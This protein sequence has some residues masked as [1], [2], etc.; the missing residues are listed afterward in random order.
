VTAAVAVDH[1]VVANHR[2]AVRRD[3]INVLAG[4]RNRH[5]A[6]S[7]VAENRAAGSRVVIAVPAA[8]V[9]TIEIVAVDVA[10]KHVNQSPTV[11]SAKSRPSRSPKK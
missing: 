7:R 4:R 8:A 10:D 5:A 1:R 3:A 2:V 6:Q 9:R 11:W